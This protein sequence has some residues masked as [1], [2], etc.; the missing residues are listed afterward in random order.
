M[1]AQELF[2]TSLFSDVNLVSYYRLENLND[3]KGS[4]NLS[5]VATVVF[6]AAKFNNGADFGSSNI[7]GS[8]G[9]D[10]STGLGINMSTACAVSLWA[11]VTTAPTSGQGTILIDWRSTTGTTSY[12]IL[13]YNNIGGVLTLLTDNGGGTVVTSAQNLGTGTWHYIVLQVQ[14]DGKTHLYL[15]NVEI[16][17]AQT[18]A[19]NNGGNALGI[20]N[21]ISGGTVGFAGLIDDC[22]F[23]SR[24]LTSAEI[25][26][27]YNGFSSG[28]TTNNLSLLGVG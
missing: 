12:Q 24:A 20:G 21:V 3:S 25:N 5:N 16:G 18:V 1:A 22:A 11:N 4:N 7:G 8:K 2:S 23:F 19:T 28:T 17:T 27:L 14:G 9:L 13:R 15:D 6:D 26:G 10:F